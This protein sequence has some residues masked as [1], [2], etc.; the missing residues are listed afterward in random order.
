M[1]VTVNQDDVDSEYRGLWSR[2]P[3]RCCAVMEGNVSQRGDDCILTAVML[4]VIYTFH[5]TQGQ[6]FHLSL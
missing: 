2:G 3:M 1:R 5:T 4:R 6:L